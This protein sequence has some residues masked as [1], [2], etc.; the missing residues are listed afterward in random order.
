MICEN[1]QHEIRENK[2]SVVT[3]TYEAPL[4]NGET[5]QVEE[6]MWVC[7][8]CFSELGKEYSKE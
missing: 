3:L 2:E 6:S 7:E 8:E 4:Q 5:T 1:C